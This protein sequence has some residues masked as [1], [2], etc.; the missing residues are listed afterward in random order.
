MPGIFGIPESLAN[1]M[2]PRCRPQLIQL[3]LIVASIGYSQNKENQPGK[4]TVDSQ[5][6][7][8]EEKAAEPQNETKQ[9]P[10]PLD[11]K[12]QG[13]TNENDKDQPKIENS[14]SSKH[15][16]S[17]AGE[18]QDQ[19]KPG[20]QDAQE[21]KKGRAIQNGPSELN[22]SEAPHPTDKN[23]GPGVEVEPL[24]PEILELLRKYEK[25]TLSTVHQ[26]ERLVPTVE[27]IPMADGQKE[28]KVTSKRKRSSRSHKVLDEQPQQGDVPATA[29]D[30]AAVEA[31]HNHR[32]SIGPK[33]E[34][35]AATISTIV[36]HPKPNL[37]HKEPTKKKK[38]AKTSM[39]KNAEPRPVVEA[40][41][42]A[43]H[44]EAKQHHQEVPQPA[45]TQNTGESG[46]KEPTMIVENSGAAKGQN[47]P[48]KKKQTHKPQ[49]TVDTT[50]KVEATL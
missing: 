6:T 50:Q 47:V 30:T 28:E 14:A 1:A 9:R 48:K 35:F 41:D 31:S 19:A 27:E 12:E 37:E 44:L 4:S 16:S 26:L 8:N 33:L 49:K 22:K 29:T 15:D 2:I 32:T 11:T 23:E 40:S 24:M 45:A 18:Q 21:E 7:E 5:P 10:Q 46:A 25:A 20:N 43:E 39:R 34:P 42:V 36:A 3:F 13:P 38:K 17:N